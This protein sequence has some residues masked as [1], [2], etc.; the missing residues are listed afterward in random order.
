MM[1]EILVTEEDLDYLTSTP[2]VVCEPAVVYKSKSEMTF[3][4]AVKA[5]N[6]ITLEEFEKRWKENIRKYIHNP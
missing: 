6:G 3:E 1:E 4:E 2:N 5:C